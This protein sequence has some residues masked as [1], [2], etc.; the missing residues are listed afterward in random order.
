MCSLRSLSDM[1]IRISIVDTTSTCI[2]YPQ[3]LSFSFSFTIVHS[4]VQNF[5]KDKRRLQIISSED[6]YITLKVEEVYIGLLLSES[7]G[8]F[9]IKYLWSHHWFTLWL[10]CW[11]MS[12][13]D[14]CMKNH[15]FPLIKVLSLGLILILD[16][17]SL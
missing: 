15:F 5:I 17:I 7:Q 1:Q 9:W 2:T 12:V 16:L 10:I 14:M 11:V 3:N 13:S 6:A 8:C 4:C